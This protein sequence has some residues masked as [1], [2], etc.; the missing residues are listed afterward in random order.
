MVSVG[1]S[2][3]Y[4][5]VAAVAGHLAWC[6]LGPCFARVLPCSRVSL[7][8]HILTII[9]KGEVTTDFGALLEGLAGNTDYTKAPQPSSMD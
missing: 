2:W 9:A 5:V 8:L 7:R 1:V 3:S 6:S 4:K